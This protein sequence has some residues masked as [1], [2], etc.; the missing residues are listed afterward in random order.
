MRHGTKMKAHDV[1]LLRQARKKAH[2]ILQK[3][4]ITAEHKMLACKGNSLRWRRCA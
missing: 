1:S 4:L 2:A 3:R